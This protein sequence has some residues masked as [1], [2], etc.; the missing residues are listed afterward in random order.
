MNYRDDLGFCSKPDK[1]PLNNKDIKNA[2][3]EKEDVKI[4]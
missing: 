1:L 2:K 4:K 3:I